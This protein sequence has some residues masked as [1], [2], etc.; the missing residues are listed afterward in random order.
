MVRWAQTPLAPTPGPSSK[1]R[2]R[3]LA[4]PGRCGSAAQD[5]GGPGGLCA[6]S[7]RSSGPGAPL[8]EAA[9]A[10]WTIMVSHEPM[11]LEQ[12]L[13]TI[14]D[15]QEG[16]VA[17][18]LSAFAG[19]DAREIDVVP[20]VHWLFERTARVVRDI[21]IPETRE[22]QCAMVDLFEG[23]AK[24]P[25]CLMSHWWGHSFMALVEAILG[26]ASGQILPAENV[27]SE[28]ELEK[29]YWLCIFGVNQHCEMDKF[30]LMM[31]HIKEHA[32]AVDRQLL[33]LTRI[34]VLKELQTALSM[35]IPTEFQGSISFTGAFELPSVRHAEASRLEDRHL[36]LQEIESSV[37][38]DAFDASI[39]QKVKEEKMKL[40]FYDA[41]VRRQVDQV[42]K[43]LQQEPSLCNIQLHQFG[44]KSP[45]HFL[46]E[47]TRS[48]TEW[49]DAS[50]RSAIL[51]ELF[52][53]RA[54]PTLR[55]AS[56]RTPLHSICMWD[57]DVKLAKRLVEQR[58]DVHATAWRGAV[59]GKTPLQ[60]LES[61]VGISP[62]LFDRGYQS[63]SARK[64]DELKEY[65]QSLGEEPADRRKQKRLGTQQAQLSQVGA[66][67]HGSEGIRLFLLQ[68]RR[69]VESAQKEH[70][71]DLE[72]HALGLICSERPKL[73][74]RLR[75]L[76]GGQER[77]SQELLCHVLAEVCGELDWL[78]P[79][80]LSRAAPFLGDE[81]TY[82]EFLAA[83]S[84][85]WFHQGAA[86]L[87]TVARATAQAELRLSG[88]AALFD[89]P[90]GMV[91]PQLAHEAL[92]QLLPS[93]RKRQR[94]QLAAS[95]FG[96][97]TTQLSAVLHQ[98]A[99][100]ADPP[101]FPEPW[102]KRG[103]Q[104]GR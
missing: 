2:W 16:M 101:Q 37:G 53:A 41:L 60:L 68:V 18:L 44:L 36:I 86:Q 97:E 74:S 73:W 55:D 31:Q 24:E 58:A 32:L 89:S 23:G 43:Q 22:R 78:G 81:V 4:E 92:G 17:E 104:M 19:T 59:R 9:Y 25:T 80:I 11:N 3:R 82:S 87:V 51:E 100:F 40:A 33:T 14:G 27:L 54:D 47:R 62:Q 84:V 50:G 10:P 65:L 69:C 91:T 28:E 96:E 76:S 26:H 56:G 72:Q 39:R 6:L 61:N 98:L 93:L 75:Q 5:G 52:R 79:Q 70:Q 34:W 57:G 66:E 85:R 49:E 77:V 99:L 94:R 38:I 83:P 21:V 13:S 88:L 102:M 63:R 15:F 8:A 35:S 42:S 29:S 30:G 103:A 12:L 64:T 48:A 95:L 67:E 20:F 46:A 1:R 71:L 90:N 45:L 7:E